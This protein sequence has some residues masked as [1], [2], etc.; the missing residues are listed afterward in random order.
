MAFRMHIPK[1]LAAAFIIAALPSSAMAVTEKDIVV[2][3]RV[4]GFLENKPKG[5][6]EIAVVKGDG[7]TQ[8]DVNEFVA[9]VGAGKTINDLTITAT[10]IDS[11]Q[12]AG[13]K[14]PV[15]FLPNN[16]SQEQ[17][18]SV[19][20]VAKA[21]KLITISNGDHC[22]IL[23]RC[24]LSVTS[25]PAVDIKISVSAAAATNVSFSSTFRMMIKEVQ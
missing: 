9:L 24:A 2:I 17:L 8:S 11:S 5:I 4:L 14:A 22:L 12:I 1:I 3:G 21:R 10:A 18:D 16:L 23:Q 13:T 20:A 6:A 25:S 19:F 7:T 15:L